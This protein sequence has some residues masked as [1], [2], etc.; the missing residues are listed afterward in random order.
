VLASPASGC[1]QLCQGPPSQAMAAGRPV[2]ACNS[3]GPRESVVHGRT[4]FLCEPTPASFAAAMLQLQVQRSA[5]LAR[6][7]Q[8]S[9]QPRTLVLRHAAWPCRH[10][11][12]GCIG[13][14]F[15]NPC[16]CRTRMWLLGWDARRD[17]MC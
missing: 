3:G 6:H 7:P 16:K 4:G 9:W 11:V 13:P 2:V 8:R 10:A 12:A 5:L 1:S 15:A 14:I 17:S